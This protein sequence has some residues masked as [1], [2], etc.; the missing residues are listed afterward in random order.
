M[1]KLHQAAAGTL[2]STIIVEL[3]CILC[4]FCPLYKYKSYLEPNRSGTTSVGEPKARAEEPKLK[5]GV[6]APA[7]APAPVYLSKT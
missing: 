5:L 4:N 6:V 7:P 2:Y 1:W 3:D